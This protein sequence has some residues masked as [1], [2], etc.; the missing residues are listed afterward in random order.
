MPS[1]L[2]LNLPAV[3]RANLWYCVIF[4]YLIFSALYLGTA[5]V[6]V[7]P[8]HVLVPTALDQA[9]PFVAASI[10][11]YLSQFLLV[12]WAVAT[13]GDDVTRSRAFYSMLLATLLSLP[14]FVL[15][16]TCVPQPPAPDDGLLGIA[17]HALRLAD[18]P[19][20]AFPSLHVALAMLAGIA[21][22]QRRQRLVALVWPGGIALSTLTTRQHVSWDIAGGLL[23]A[24][25]AWYLTPRLVPYE[26]TARH[27]R[28]SRG[29]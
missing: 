18:T 23:V 2:T 21:L 1:H 12:P 3:T 20:N 4:G 9:V 17:W 28:N 5:V 15:Y 24:T 8:A 26:R 13:A 25:L 7:R 10:W 29:T 22:W 11:V 16:P 14:V 6:A 27:E 19:Y